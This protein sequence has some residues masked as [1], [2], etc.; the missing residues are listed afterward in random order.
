MGVGGSLNHRGH[1]E[2]GGKFP[3]GK[4]GEKWGTREE[5]PGCARPDSR[6][7]LSPHDYFS[8]VPIL[9][10]QNAA[11]MGHPREVGHR[12][13]DEEVKVPTLSQRARQGWGTRGRG[14][15]PHTKVDGGE[16]A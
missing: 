3:T 6:G 11:R 16:H 12:R 10:A 1:R 14:R 2:H 8:K 13:A 7:R 4:S 5:L 15:P 9:A